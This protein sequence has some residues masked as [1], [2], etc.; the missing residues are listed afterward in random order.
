[1][2]RSAFA[3]P[4]AKGEFGI[5]EPQG[6][7]C[8]RGDA[9]PARLLL[10]LILESIE[11]S[12]I[13]LG[14]AEPF[15]QSAVYNLVGALFG[16]SELTHHFSQSAKLFVRICSIVKRHFSHP[17]VGP[18]EVAAE[19]GI[20][21]R[22]LQKLFA[23]RGTTCSHYIRSLRLD[24]AAQLLDRETPTKANIPLGEIA[25][26]CG[27]RDYANFARHFRARFRDT[28]GAFRKRALSQ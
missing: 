7:L 26:S 10:R 28:P 19:A 20:S 15:M 6:G 16:A 18:A 27:Y 11:E 12:E 24:H 22:Y 14:S 13:G 3:T 21:V 2:D 17:D 8:W 23:A 9:L 1:M 5:L 4:A 25:H